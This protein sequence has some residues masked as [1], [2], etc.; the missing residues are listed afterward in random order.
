MA[1]KKNPLDQKG[2]TPSG[3]RWEIMPI[4]ELDVDTIYWDLRPITGAEK[5]G[6]QPR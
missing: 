5:T 3:K 1:I 2:I 6:S 4:P